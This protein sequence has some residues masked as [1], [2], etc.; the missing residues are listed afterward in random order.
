[1]GIGI[2]KR[3]VDG[4]KFKGAEG[5]TVADK[6]KGVLAYWEP[7][8]FNGATSYGHTGC[9]VLVDPKMI[10]KFVTDDPVQNL[11]IVKVTPGTSWVYYAGACWDKGLD[12]KDRESWEKY[13]KEYKTEFD[14]K[15]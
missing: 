12:L 3:K 14:P 13:A 10:V 6:E 8:Q 7:E 11:V 5:V 2:A 15:K 1:V 9:A 4:T